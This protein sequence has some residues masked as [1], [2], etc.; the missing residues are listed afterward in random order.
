[1]HGWVRSFV[2]MQTHV[3]IPL[4]N[5]YVCIKL[6]C[7]LRG[8]AVVGVSVDV[9]ACYQYAYSTTVSVKVWCCHGCEGAHVCL[10]MFV[11]VHARAHLYTC[12]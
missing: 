3:Y 12:I 10:R 11:C 7:V 5:Q 8:C 2:F 1:V 4:H 9:R 6:M